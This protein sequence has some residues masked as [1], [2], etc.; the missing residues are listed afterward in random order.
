[1]REAARFEL[2]DEFQR[3]EGNCVTH[4]FAFLDAAPIC[5]LSRAPSRAAAR[6]PQPHSRPSAVLFDELDAGLFI[7]LGVQILDLDGLG[8]ALSFAQTNAGATSVPLDELDAG[9]FEHRADR[10]EVVRH[11]RG[12]PI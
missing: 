3:V 2:L 5:S 4:R 10:G 9:L 7:I 6:A 8:C 12:G 11:S 1:M